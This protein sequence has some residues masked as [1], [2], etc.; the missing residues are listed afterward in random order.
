MD[1]ETLLIR[2]KNAIR[3]SGDYQNDA[4]LEL[5][6]QV[7]QDMIDMGVQ[8]SVVDSSASVGAIT[9]GVWDKDN[10]HEYS[11]DFEKQ[12]IRLREKEG[13]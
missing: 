9:K 11:L 12:V 10:L 5:I 7:K 2:V 8:K 13:A 6:N 4:L 1:N 3:I